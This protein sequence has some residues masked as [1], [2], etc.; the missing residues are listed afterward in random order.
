MSRSATYRHFMDRR[1]PSGTFG[2]PSMPGKYGLTVVDVP[3]LMTIG[4]R[5]L[6][7]LIP[8]RVIIQDELII[9]VFR[10]T[11]NVGYAATGPYLS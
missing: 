2:S 3:S 4:I 5:G 6:T 1:F 9:F 10:N 11:R 8:L 7:I